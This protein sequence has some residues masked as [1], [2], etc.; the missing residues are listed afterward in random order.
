MQGSDQELGHKAQ[1]GPKQAYTALTLWASTQGI[2]CTG[3]S[4]S[5]P[6]IFFPFW[7]SVAGSQM[8]YK[9]REWKKNGLFFPYYIKVLYNLLLPTFI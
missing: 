2:L 3:F 6:K 9:A 5:G 4:K 7:N 1:D 8:C